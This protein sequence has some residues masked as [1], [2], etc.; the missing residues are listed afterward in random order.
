MTISYVSATFAPANTVAMPSHA[1]GD[2]I[3][4]FTVGMSEPALPAGWTN[5][6]TWTASTGG[7]TYHLRLGY[8]TAASSSETTGTW[9]NSI[10]TAVFVYRTTL[11]WQTPTVATSATT[12]PDLANPGGLSNWFIRSG[13]SGITLTTG[14]TSRGAVFDSGDVAVSASSVGDNASGSGSLGT[15]TIGISDITPAPMHRTK[16]WDGSAWVLGVPKYHDG[17]SWV[18]ANLKYHDGSAWVPA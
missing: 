16:Y 10:Q 1:A 6:A 18:E 8:K 12:Y 14:W 17:T 3:M 7:Q 11:E 2:L 13:L 5:L 15:F 4:C 9:T